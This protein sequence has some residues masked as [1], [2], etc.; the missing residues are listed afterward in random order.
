MRFSPPESCFST[1]GN[2]ASSI[3]FFPKRK[4]VLVIKKSY[5]YSFFFFFFYKLFLRKL[6]LS[7]ARICSPSGTPITDK[8]GEKKKKKKKKRKEKKRKEK[9]RKEKKR[10]RKPYQILSVPPF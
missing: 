1:E 8:E 4:S 9:K 10:K 6:N 7:L 5:Y 3:A 2:L